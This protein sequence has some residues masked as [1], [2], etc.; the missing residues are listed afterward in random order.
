MP[1]PTRCGI[2]SRMDDTVL[3]AMQKW[4]NV[5]SV[6]GWLALDRRGNWLI[7]SKTGQFERVSNRA[8][9]DFIGRNY[10]NDEQGRWFLQNGPQRVFVT[11]DYTPWIYRLDDSG[12]QLVTHTDAIPKD[13]RALFLDDS[14]G[15]LIE[16]DLGIGV[17]LD[18]DLPAVLE[19]LQGTGNEDAEALIDKVSAGNNCRARLF[20]QAVPFAPVRANEVPARFRFNPRPAP[21]PGQPDC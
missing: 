13:L 12:R 16:T 11:L 20:G 19:Q 15:V 21:P 14:G 17:V 3:R 5:P 4:P 9:T 18:R 8:M 10:A 7:K 2:I 1:F 6:Y